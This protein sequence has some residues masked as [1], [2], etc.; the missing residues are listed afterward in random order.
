MFF[1]VKYWYLNNP[2]KFVMIFK[3]TIIRV[4]KKKLHLKPPNYFKSILLLFLYY[5]KIL[6]NILMIK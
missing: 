4:F 2:S 1:L 6:H 3:N 5:I